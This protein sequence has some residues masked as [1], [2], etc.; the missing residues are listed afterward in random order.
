MWRPYACFINFPET[1]LEKYYS[2][3]SPE[4]E[5]FFGSTI[6]NVKRLI[7]RIDIDPVV[8][9]CKNLPFQVQTTDI[10]VC[11]DPSSGVNQSQTYDGTHQGLQGGKVNMLIALGVARLGRHPPWR[12][13]PLS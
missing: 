10:S 13:N 3:L 4:D 1:L 12:R 11:T 9:A 5:M 7:G 2:G 8:Q 6:F